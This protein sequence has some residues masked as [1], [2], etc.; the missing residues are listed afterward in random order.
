MR[1]VAID[2]PLRARVRACSVCFMI[3]AMRT[4]FTVTA[5]VSM[6]AL[7]AC[8]SAAPTADPSTAPAPDPAVEVEAEGAPSDGGTSEGGISGEGME[9]G[10]NDQGE[11]PL[12][13]S[14]GSPLGD[15]NRFEYLDMGME[16]DM[17]L[18]VDWAGDVGTPD[19]S[20]IEYPDGLRIDFAGATPGS[21]PVSEE[22]GD[23]DP[24][25]ALV[26]LT[27]TV[28]NAGPDALPLDGGM[29]P[30]DVFEGENLTEVSSLTGYFDEEGEVSSV[31]D[32]SVIAPGSSIDV[33]MSYEV[34][35][36]A[37]LQVEILPAFFGEEH[38]PFVFY[39][40][41]AP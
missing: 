14:T 1:D 29:R 20:F 40:I 27:V 2:H 24:D 32:A 11:D 16:Y 28:T 39:G 9:E 35:P 18:G 17:A 41:T 13:V 37:D 21:A 10:D 5:A 25:K 26:R 7:A 6:L 22:Q 38:T 19:G 4:T 15:A 8:S 36:G 33:F 30:L 3:N 34:T 12:A 31:N 23:L